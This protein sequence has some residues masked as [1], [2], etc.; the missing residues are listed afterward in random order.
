MTLYRAP[1]TVAD[2][3]ARVIRL[4]SE[5]EVIRAT[6]KRLSFFYKASH[7]NSRTELDLDDA[8]SLDALLES[9]GYQPEFI[10]LAL[11]Q[12]AATLRRLGGCQPVAV[13]IHSELHR[14]AADVGDLCRVVDRAMEDGQLTPPERRDIARESQDVMDRARLI[15]D[16][17]E[18]PVANVTQLRETA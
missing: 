9:K 12:K 18:P 2:T 7:P 17:V 11:E 14:L 15:R 1:G 16:H 4:F 6:G 10:P 13:C 3:L 8:A 5:E